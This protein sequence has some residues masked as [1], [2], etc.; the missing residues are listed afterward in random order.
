MVELQVGQTWYSSCYERTITKITKQRVYYSFK[1]VDTGS[2]D[3][4]TNWKTIKRFKY[5][6]C[7]RLILNQVYEVW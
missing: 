2:D 5:D 7:K 3:K 4:G 1:C 6:N